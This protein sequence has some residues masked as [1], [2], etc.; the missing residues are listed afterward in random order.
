MIFRRKT[1]KGSERSVPDVG[2][3]LERALPT[4]LRFP[5]FYV[6]ANVRVAGDLHVSGH[7][8]V[9]GTV[10]GAVRIGDRTLTIGRNGSVQGDVHAGTVLIQGRLAGD[11]HASEGVEIA[12]GAVVCGDIRAPRFVLDPGARFRGQ[13]HRPASAPDVV[14]RRPWPVPHGD[15]R[16]RRPRSRPKWPAP[17]GASAPTAPVAS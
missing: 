2:E 4:T 12:A 5:Q 14:V 9:E 10:E 16:A 8:H 15:D 6:T 1:S 17:A 7:A 13:V 3:I 11:V